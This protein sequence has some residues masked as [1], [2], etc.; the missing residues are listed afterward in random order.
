MPEYVFYQKD[1]HIVV[2]ES[3]ATDGV[4]SLTEQGYEKQFEAIEAAS[5]NAALARLMDIR[6]NNQIDRD[7]FLA[8]AGEMPLIGA[9][10]ALATHLVSKKTR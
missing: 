4:L 7:N 2:Q 5:E 1:T 8:G 9:L 10:A 6:R 3:T